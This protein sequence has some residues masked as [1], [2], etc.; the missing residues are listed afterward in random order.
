MTKLTYPNDG[1]YKYC[2]DN[3]ECCR[4]SLYKSISGISLDIPSSFAY[5]SYLRNLPN[6][7]TNYY[8]EINN[9]NSKLQSSNNNYEVLSSELSSAINKMILIKVKRRDRMI[10]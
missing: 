2:K 8:K 5:K 9:I 10:I 3:I 4:N 7:L 6:V 1:I